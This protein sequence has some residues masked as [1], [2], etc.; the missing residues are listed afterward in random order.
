VR[1]SLDILARSV[2]SLTGAHRAAHS[3]GPRGVLF[4]AGPTGVGKTE[5]AKALTELVFGDSSAYTRFDMSEFADAS[6]AAR[7]IGA[8]PGYVGFDAGGELTNA[9]RERPFSLI[10]FD[11][12]EKADRLIFDKFL[13]ILED[14]R[15]TDGRGGTVVFTEAIL[16]FTSNLGISSVG[17]DG[18]RAVDVGPGL[19]RGEAE[20]R[21]LEA[22]RSFFR[23]ELVNR[24]GSN[25]IVFDYIDEGSAD[26]ILQRLLD[27][28]AQRVER[29][30]Q[31]KLV[32][33]PAARESLA[34]LALADLSNG[35]RGIGS[36]VED[37]LVN[38][39]ARRLILTP[40]AA[41]AELRVEAVRAVGGSFELDCE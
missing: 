24:L 39:L 20:R 21:V 5:L 19:D 10:L 37:A 41:D 6:T 31:A 30:C 4:F 7:L 16:V 38:P 11:E 28:V 18:K 17:A 9:V 25:I 3:I 1:R 26:R 23:P 2:T 33:A 15:L 40:P 36:A 32:L 12:I 34:E 14:G 27:N 35:G 29:E 22:I 8:P 13:Q